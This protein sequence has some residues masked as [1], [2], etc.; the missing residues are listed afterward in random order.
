[1]R[2]FLRKA[3]ARSLVTA[4]A[5]S[6]SAITASSATAYTDGPYSDVYYVNSC[7]TSASINPAP[8][9]SPSA[10]GFMTT[11][12]A[13][14]S[15]LGGLQIDAGGGVNNGDIGKWS[16]ITPTP[17]MRIVGVNAS[18]YA[19]CNLHGDGFNA[20]YFYGDNG[21]NYGVP[22]ITIDCH[23]ASGNSN[24]G[25][26]SGFI[27]PS[28]Y[29]GFQASC[30]KAGGCTPTGANGL[31]FAATGITLAVQEASGPALTADAANNLY[32]QSGWVRGTFPANLSASDVSG[33]CAMQTTVN[34]QAITSY[35]DPS[36]DTSQWSQCH[37]G[38]ISGSVDTSNYP[39]GS[40]AV[41]LAYSATN[42]AGA[43]SSTSRAIDV[44][45]VAP[46]VSLSA[47]ADTASTS[48]TQD[49]TVTGSAGP[50]GVADI[51]CSV[52]GAPTQTYSGA[53]AQVPVSGIGSHQVTCF[54]RNH[55]VNSCGVA[56]TSAPQTLDLSIRQPTAEA[57]TFAR[58]ADALKCHT[59]IEQV[60]V[61]GRL[62]TVR[63]HGKRVRVRRHAR[64]VRRRVRKCHARSVVRTVRVI[65]KR[66]GK[67]V[68]RHGK[69]VYVK[70]RVRKVLL[71]HVVNQ[72][73][74]DIG[75]GKR[76]TVSGFLEQADGTALGGQTV[77]VLSAPDDNAPRFHLMRTVT[78]NA[79][80]LWTAKVGPGP[81]R[82]I[83]AA[84]PGT[85]TTEPAVSSA[86]TLTVPARIALS[87][88]PRTLP[89][90][91]AIHLHGRMVGGY[92]PRDGVALRLL[93]RYPAA[94][95]WTPLL[96]LRT[97]RHGRFSFTWSYHAGRGV[98]SYPFAIATTATESDY[99]W[100]AASSR[101]LT[102]TF[103]RPTP[104]RP[105]HHH[106]RRRHRH[107]R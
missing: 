104:P 41:T 8:V 66:H 100:A 14:P 81:S 29:F 72:A 10:F 106:R 18:G 30:Q 54:D 32:Y 71:P 9:F 68:H 44:D 31:V 49:V 67:P 23:G 86:V 94:K 80:G 88:S 17:G 57:I 48:G 4:V 61:A 42:A 91:A 102:A 96:A 58:I 90:H 77:Q 1:M 12:Q 33:V 52:D 62:H 26:L 28:R 50:S 2:A 7:A 87:I 21:L 20:S 85:Q 65:L 64:T 53:S 83:E 92:V 75:H 45:N 101:A 22:Q 93:V 36:R 40:A 73:T 55:A 63:R 89:W 99:P 16:A 79:D 38:R 103:G 46:S 13:C 84:Y 59:A 105:H 25:E 60:K 35:S 34:G 98:A 70:R 51:D 74:R 95:Q 56:A 37:G 76:T 11:A 43:V 39:N 6:T 78:T 27:Q 15:G 3:A 24:A 5:L 97:N 69:L 19:D 82:L 107:H 47:P